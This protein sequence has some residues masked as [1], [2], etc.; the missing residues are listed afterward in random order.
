LGGLGKFGSGGQGDGFSSG[1][2]QFLANISGV[3]LWIEAVDRIKQGLIMQSPEQ[4][5]PARPDV[6]AQ[7]DKVLEALKKVDKIETEEQAKIAATYTGVASKVEK[8]INDARLELTRPIDA[9]KKA[10]MD[11]YNSVI[12]PVAKERQRVD[13]LWAAY[14]NK[15]KKAAEAAAE[16]MRREAEEAAKAEANKI[17]AAAKADAD[18]IAAEAKAEA[19][20]LAAQGNTAEAQTVLEEAGIAI[21]QTKTVAQE[22]AQ[23]VIQE[24]A[25]A[26][27]AAPAVETKTRTAVGTRFLRDNWRIEALPGQAVPATIICKH[28]GGETPTMGKG[29]LPAEY[30]SPDQ[31]KLNKVVDDGI[32]DLDGTRIWNDQTVSGR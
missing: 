3:V 18:R 7:A 9:Q 30:F 27:I 20:A 22:Q 21:E 26:P 5:A 19:D 28:C 16:K 4:A 17:A 24:A 2:C 14:Q 29:Q 10:I 15:L 12:D 31:K 32:R 6:F 13:K 25:A 23:A 1:E 11:E 8:A